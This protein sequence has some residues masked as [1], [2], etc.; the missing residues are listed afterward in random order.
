[1]R[2]WH[3]HDGV[4]SG[5]SACQYSDQELAA[6]FNFD[7]LRRNFVHANEDGWHL[8]V[9]GETSVGDILPRPKY[10]LSVGIAYSMSMVLQ[11]R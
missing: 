2:I 9:W 4:L 6:A 8:G 11:F 5:V 10:R 7:L 3:R 1:M